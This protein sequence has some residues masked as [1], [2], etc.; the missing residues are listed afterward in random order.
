MVVSPRAVGLTLC[1]MLQLTIVQQPL[2]DY[3]SKLQFV[4]LAFGCALVLHVQLQQLVFEDP[5]LESA[6]AATTVVTYSFLLLSFL[7]VSLPSL[8]RRVGFPLNFSLSLQRSLSVLPPSSLLLFL[9]ALADGGVTSCRGA[10][11]MP[12]AAADHRPAAAY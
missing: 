9:S 11:A 3:G 5:S 1:L 7:S 12:D 4:W 8:A 10:D 2:T 6:V